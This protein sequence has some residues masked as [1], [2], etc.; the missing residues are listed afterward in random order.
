MEIQ[1]RIERAE[2]I[3]KAR[4]RAWDIS[5]LA[6]QV[7]EVH[8]TVAKSPDNGKPRPEDEAVVDAAFARWPPALAA[9]LAAA[10]GAASMDDS[11]RG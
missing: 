6:E 1:R 8:I 3:V 5:L 11:T 9:R 10:C 7:L 2:W 4:A